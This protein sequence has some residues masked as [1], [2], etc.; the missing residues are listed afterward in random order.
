MKNN[1][2]TQTFKE[3]VMIASKVKGLKKIEYKTR[4]KYPVIDQGHNFITAYSD[5]K[6][7]LQNNIPF[8]VFGDHTRIIKYIDTPVILGN[9]GIKI[10]RPKNEIESKYLYYFLSNLKIPN[11]G[12][13]RHF[14]LL[15]QNKIIV[16]DAN[17]QKK[18]VNIL[19]SIDDDI[20]KT[21]KIIQKTEDLKQGL[22]QEL[23][24]KGIGNKKFKKTKFGR[25]SEDFINIK[26]GEVSY[27]TKL[28]G[29]E[30]TKFFNSYKT[31]GEIIVIRGQNIKN[32][33]LDFLNIKTISKEISNQLPRS[34]LHKGDLVFSYVGTIGPIAL[35]N[36]DDKFHLGPNTCKIT[37]N[38]TILPKY[39]YYYFCSN[40]IK[41]EIQKK[42]SVGAQPSLSMEKIRTFELVIPNNIRDQQRIVAILNTLENKLEIEKNNKQKLIKTRKGLMIDIFSQKVQ[43][44]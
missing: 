44:N 34:Q 19:T 18:I 30:F 42:I 27:I 15:I 28:A 39:L 21:D 10:L 20:Q 2:K 40:L 6:D 5:R 31:T 17:I 1:Y 4:A 37:P 8:I 35:I 25:T 43:V 32:N 22:M 14:K 24:T 26:L 38:K 23:L 13:N 7:L 36:N 9:D 16:P 41:G 3:S 33:N 12:Y 11:T 29:Y